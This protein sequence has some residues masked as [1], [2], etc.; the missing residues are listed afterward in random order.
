MREKY[1]PETET[2]NIWWEGSSHET[3]IQVLP[4]QV[5]FVLQ[6]PGTLDLFA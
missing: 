1:A 2:G 3:G 5:G 6:I 4:V